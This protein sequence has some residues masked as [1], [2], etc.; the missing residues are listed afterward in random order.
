MNK[1]KLFWSFATRAAYGCFSD[2]TVQSV[3][4]WDR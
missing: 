3:A 1:C 4:S 2:T